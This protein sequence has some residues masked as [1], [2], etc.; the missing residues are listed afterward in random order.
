[1]EDS[2]GVPYQNLYNQLYNTGYAGALSWQWLGDT[3]ANDNAKNSDHSRT[4]AALTD[5]FEN[6][7]ADIVLF[8]KSGTIY[9][10]K[11]SP[12]NVQKDDSCTVTWETEVGSGVTINNEALAIS[13]SK[14]YI[15]NQNTTFTLTTT[16]ENPQTRSISVK[17]IPSGT[18]IYFKV[19]PKELP[20][21]DTARVVWTTAKGSEVKINGA[22]VPVSGTIYVVPDNNN[23]SYEITTSG[24]VSDS[25]TGYVSFVAAD[26]ANRSYGGDFTVSSLDSTIINNKVDNLYDGNYYTSWTSLSGSTQTVQVDLQKVYDINKIVLTWGASYSKSYQIYSS[27][28][29]LTWNTIKL[30]AGGKGGTE[31]YNL[32]AQGRYVK[33][34]MA[35]STSAPL[36]MSEFEIY[37]MPVTTAVISG[38]TLPAV[39]S[40]EQNYPNPF[41][42]STVI[43]YQIPKAGNVSLKIFDILGREVI[44]L[45]NGIQS[46]GSY[47]VE[48][49]AKQF[50]SGVYFYRLTAGDFIQV[51]KMLLMK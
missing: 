36:V 13:G 6:H 47:K 40:L 39:Y 18:I 37:G 8:I 14:S 32:T 42:P 23:T 12:L 20:L 44:T 3:Q 4:V 30:Q 22:S 21:G 43:N 45:V 17:Y 41:N 35:S 19:K 48:L 51:K 9:K 11:V 27:L 7:H 31:T 5:L 24:E 38:N 26:Q 28:D 50:T 1:M 33:L 15:P 25:K 46:A 2:F 29:G 34:G 49:N 16:G 10:F